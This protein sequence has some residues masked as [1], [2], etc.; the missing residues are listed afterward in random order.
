MEKSK[1]LCLVVVCL[2]SFFISTI[3]LA[4]TA[5]ADSTIK[6][7]I[8][9]LNDLYE[10]TS[11]AGGKVGG[12]ARLAT[13]RKN[14][15]Q[16]NPNT[17]M[18]LAGDV[19]S[20]SAL[21][22]A[23]VD[24][25]RLAGKQIVAVLNAI[26]LNY[27]TFGNH[28]FDLREPQLLQRLKESSFTWFS[29]NVRR[30]GGSYF[31]DVADSVVF[32]VTD[33][34]NRQ[35]HI[36]MF[37]LTLDSNRQPYVAYAD[38]FETA[39]QRLAAMRDKVD[40]LIALTHLRIDQDIALANA[41]PEIDLIMGGHEHE[42]I[43]LWR[44]A[45]LTPIF[46]AD[47]NVRTVYIHDL[48]YNTAARELKISS[49]LQPIDAAIQEDPETAK[50]VQQ[51]VEIAYAAFKK[52]G[53]DPARVVTTS[54]TVL[55]GRE[56]S[57]RNQSTSLT[58]LIALGMMKAAGTELAVFNGGSIRIDDELPPGPVTEYDVIRV[59][60]FGGMVLSVEMKGSLL[61]QVLKQGQ[62]NKGSGGFLQTA[63]I[64][65]SEDE[66]T[67]LIKGSSIDPQKT[68]VL[69]I[70]DFLVTG[71]EQGLDFLNRDNKDLRV[72]KE[73]VDVRKALIEQLK[74]AFGSK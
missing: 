18:V 61:S 57:V 5:P 22:T 59:L 30:T 54:P 33:R 23:A 60:P 10:I 11:V 3:S 73:H 37:G 39:K 71:R 4:Q 72:L 64:S 47:A 51:W 63:G 27:S 69:A 32:T 68:Y 44:G 74:T 45:E 16:Q 25:D 53:F 14:L 65:R 46:K 19:L 17:F 36:G 26:G 52:A 7:S 35:V 49:R 70:N 31:P 28:E 15:L 38:P 43:Q 42:N 41:F 1:R 56:A 48:L 12:L 50:L 40:I 24:G 21:G 2:L 55:D 67:W 66:S 62:V 8:I 6:I 34:E 13:L 58:D 20:P 9:H 29:S